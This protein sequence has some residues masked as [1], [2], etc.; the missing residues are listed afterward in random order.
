[1]ILKNEIYFQS[2]VHVESHKRIE[3]G[4]CMKF[5]EFDILLRRDQCQCSHD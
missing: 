1:M 3:S 2:I 4:I 5:D